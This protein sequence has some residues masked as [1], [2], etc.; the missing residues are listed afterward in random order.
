VSSDLHTAVRDSARYLRNVRPVDPAELAEYVEGG[1]HPAAV[2]Q[3]LREQATDLDLVEREDGTFVP[4]SEEPVRPEFDGVAA[5]PE[6]HARRVED[7]LVGAYGPD[8]HRG[9]SGAALRERIR[10]LKAAYHDGAP[11]EYDRDTALAYAVYHLPNYY[12]VGQYVCEDLVRD[13]LLGGRL[14][15]LDVGAGVGGPALGLADYLP[16]DALVE[17]EAI[18]PSAAAGVLRDLLAGTGRNVHA[19]V[20][21]TTAEAFDPA[22]PYDLVLFAN[23][24]SELAEPTATAGRYLDA[25]ADDGTLAAVAPADRNTSTHLRRV[26]RDLVRD[27]ATV[28]APTVRLWEGLEPTDRGWSFDRRPDIEAPAVQRRLAEQADVPGEI[29]NT[30]VKFSYALLR[31]DGRRRHERSLS[32]VVAAPLA[33]SEEHVTDRVTHVVAK[34]SRDLADG[35]RPLY[36]ISDGSE[37]VEHYAVLVNDTALNRPLREAGYGD[38][39]RVDEGLVLWNDDEGAYNVVVD[40]ETVVDWV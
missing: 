22:G 10:D 25:L 29:T 20:H 21:E 39:L 17:Y 34:L 8:W 19:T 6:R 24:L 37:S 33:A 30:T 31:T 36:K 2:R 18:E 16:E 15:V 38:L 11:V 28:Y 35:G 27:G 40:E 12:A 4:A 14:R 26:E 32:R 1:A 3:A 9:D 13:G 23:V 7:C 5:L